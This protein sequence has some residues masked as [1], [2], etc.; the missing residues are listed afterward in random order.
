MAHAYIYNLYSAAWVAGIAG[1][2]IRC[3]F[4]ADHSKRSIQCGAPGKSIGITEGKLLRIFVG[5][6]PIRFAYERCHK[7]I[8]SKRNANAKQYVC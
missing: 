5:G 7:F 3:I 2:V 8:L 4:I 6:G 1:S